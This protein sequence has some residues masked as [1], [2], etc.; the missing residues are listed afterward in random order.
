VTPS[1]RPTPLAAPT[2]SRSPP[3]SPNPSSLTHRWASWRS[4]A[5]RAR[6]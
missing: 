5:P 3:A 6:T 1:A 2:R 4:R